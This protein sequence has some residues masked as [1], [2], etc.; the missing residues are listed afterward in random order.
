MTVPSF[1]SFLGE[2]GGG[3]GHSCDESQALNIYCVWNWKWFMRIAVDAVPTVLNFIMCVRMCRS[4]W[5][6]GLRRRSAA[7]RLLWSW[8]Q[9]PP[10]AWLSLCCTLFVLSLVQMSPTDC[11][12]CLECDQVQIKTLYTYCKQVGRRGKDYETKRVRMLI[13]VIHARCPLSWGTH[14][15][16]LFECKRR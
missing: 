12:V 10:G 14:M 6:R 15:S 1:A 7:E 16:A 8:V 13:M 2:D 9:I 3:R 11:G 5:P 4:Q